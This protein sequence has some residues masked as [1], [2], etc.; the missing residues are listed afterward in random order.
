MAPSEEED[1]A[2]P[3]EEIVVPPEEEDDWPQWR[4][5]GIY[6]L[7]SMIL[8]VSF[9]SLVLVTTP[10]TPPPFE[11]KQMKLTSPRPLVIYPALPEEVR[12]WARTTKKPKGGF[13]YNF[14]TIYYWDSTTTKT[15]STSTS[16]TSTSTTS[17]STTSASTTSSSTTQT[18]T[19]TASFNNHSSTKPETVE[20]VF[21]HRPGMYILSSYLYVYC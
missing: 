1:V 10:S 15:T 2:P 4:R 12:W 19:S 18:T 9:G 20:N 13:K 7:V 5:L 3:K 14:T 11:H 6:H 21:V 17:T 8:I 16:T